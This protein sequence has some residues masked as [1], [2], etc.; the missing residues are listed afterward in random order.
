MNTPIVKLPKVLKTDL[1]LD[2]CDT[3]ITE[4]PDDLQV[5]GSIWV[6]PYQQK[7][8]DFAKSGKFAKKITIWRK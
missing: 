4:L 2:L 5:C 7:L 6:K 1:G 8:I 3:N